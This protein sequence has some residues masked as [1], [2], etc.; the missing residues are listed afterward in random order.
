MANNDNI[1]ISKL[2]D[3]L[4]Q[5]KMSVPEFS[6]QTHIP[7]DRVYKWRQQGTN[8]KSEDEKIILAWLGE[9]EIVP[10]EAKREKSEYTPSGL[11]EAMS[12]IANLTESN[13]MLAEAQLLLAKNIN[14]E[15]SGR[16]SE[17]EFQEGRDTKRAVEIIPLSGKRK[18][19][20]QR[21][22]GILKS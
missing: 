4:K 9:M 17:S 12:I 19:E 5:R 20:K 21:Q 13:R 15:R 22:R 14:S 11:L 6:L 3:A 16:A 1:L 18:D 2:F 7:K 10:R 8:P